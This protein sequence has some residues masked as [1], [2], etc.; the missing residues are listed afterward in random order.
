MS[1]S[2]VEKTSMSSPSTNGLMLLVTRA[3]ESP[4]SYPQAMVKTRYVGP[5]IM[6]TSVSTAS[7][8][9]NAATISRSRG[10]GMPGSYPSVMR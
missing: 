1:T 5:S 3:Q 7:R 2:E 9:S 10:S 4:A 6:R 8:A